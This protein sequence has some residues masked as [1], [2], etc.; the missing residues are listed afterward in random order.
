VKAGCASL[1]TDAAYQRDSE[2]K[3]NDEVPELSLRSR[4]HLR[5]L[6]LQD[7]Q[8]TIAGGVGRPRPNLMS[9]TSLSTILDHRKQFLGFVQRRVSDSEVAEDI[10]QAAY[11][12]ALQHEGEIRRGESVV[13]WF[14]RVLRNAVIDYYRRRSSENRALEA[15]GRELETAVVPSHETHDEVCGCLGGVLDSIKPDYAEV[16]RAVDLGEQPLQDFARERNISA[17]NAGVR[18]H[19]ARTALRKQLIR[20]CGSCAEHACLDC[21][22]RR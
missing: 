4:L 21:I 22:C 16:L 19:R 9:E 2:E 11:M 5:G 6:H 10:L 17:S 14:Y 1:G 18:A 15:W 12:R 13:A 7:E 20:T 8:L 3:Q